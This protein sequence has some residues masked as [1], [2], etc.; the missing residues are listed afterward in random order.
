METRK[1]SPSEEDDPSSLIFRK[2]NDH[3]FGAFGVLADD[4]DKNQ[5]NFD[6]NFDLMNPHVAAA[7]VSTAE[8]IDPSQNSNE[9]STLINGSNLLVNTFLISNHLVNGVGGGE[10][11]SNELPASLSASELNL[12]LK[13]AS[14]NSFADHASIPPSSSVIDQDDLIDRRDMLKQLYIEFFLRNECMVDSNLNTFTSKSTKLTKS[15]QRKLFHLHQSINQ[16]TIYASEHTLEKFSD[17]SS[18]NFAELTTAESEELVTRVMQV[19]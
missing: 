7:A 9:R 16:T 17:S 5:H 12:L 15:M 19:N 10:T 6:F 4:F 13:T 3:T 2:P 1:K 14:A 8:S 18:I 11:R